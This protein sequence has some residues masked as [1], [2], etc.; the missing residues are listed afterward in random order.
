M[1]RVRLHDDLREKNLEPLELGCCV[2]LL[3]PNDEE[4]ELNNF[5]PEPPLLLKLRDADLYLMG[6]SCSSDINN[7]NNIMC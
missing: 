4:V 1:L 2:I 3:T 6:D 5:S 7:F